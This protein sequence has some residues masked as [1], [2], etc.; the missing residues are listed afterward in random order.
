MSRGTKAS[1]PP[2]SRRESRANLKT[3]LLGR[4][5]AGLESPLARSS[6]SRLGPSPSTGHLSA[7][8][9]SRAWRPDGSARQQTPTPAALRHVGVFGGPREVEPRQVPDPPDIAR[10][11]FR[12]PKYAGNCRSGARVGVA[13]QPLSDEAKRLLNFCTRHVCSNAAS[14]HSKASDWPF[15]CAISH[16]AKAIT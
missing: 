2:S 7:R 8:Y 11:N 1:N 4:G 16:Q 3:T 10:T 9:C 14:R 5:I 13:A 15:D 12:R 6:A